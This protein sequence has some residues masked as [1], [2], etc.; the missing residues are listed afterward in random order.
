MD[1]ERTGRSDDLERVDLDVRSIAFFF[2]VDPGAPEDGAR[3]LLPAA[4]VVDASASVR[5]DLGQ[6]GRTPLASVHVD[7]SGDV[8]EIRVFVAAARLSRRG[9]DR[10]LRAAH[11]CLAEDGSLLLVLRVR[12]TGGLRLE[13]G[14]GARIEVVFH[15][16]GDVEEDRVACEDHGGEHSDGGSSG[17]GGG[18]GGGGGGD[19]GGGLPMPAARGGDDEGEPP[20]CEEQEDD[21]DDGD[22][23]TRLEFVVA[24]SLGC[25]D[26]S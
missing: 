19:G 21:D 7:R 18:R 23:G 10:L 15:A 2:D 25:H 17:P 5:L 6:E 26:A 22:D 14:R 11:T 13:D 1:F 12:P 20:E 8:R 4:T 3:C 16:R 9:Q 24:E